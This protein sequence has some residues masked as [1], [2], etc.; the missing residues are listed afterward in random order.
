MYE[1]SS[2]TIVVEQEGAVLRIRLNR[3][4]RFNAWTY[5]LVTAATKL[6][7]Q[8]EDDW[9]IRA[10]V[11]EG[12][13]PAFCDGDDWLDMGEWPQEYAH[14]RPGGSHGPAPI[15]QQELLRVV[16]RLPKPTIAVMHGYA[17]GVG[18]DLACACDI[19]VCTDDT[20]LGDPRIHQARHVATG[21]TYTLPRLIGQS[22]AMRFLLL[23]E[24][25][26][27]KEAEHIGLVY[28][29]FPKDEFSRGVEQ[30]LAQLATMATRS[31][32]IIKQQL[33]DELDM[34]YETALMHS[35]AIRQTNVIEDRLEGGRAFLEKRDARFGGR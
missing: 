19:R 9:E 7:R 11:F 34:S 21:I 13:G 27:G 30:L 23:G 12:A 22:Q 8:A 28:K 17:L 33:L 35:M 20:I 4:D 1:S 32:A 29:S 24:Q 15:L 2:T 3:P 14:R 16:R 26:N 5:E 18:L 6:T 25:L 10:V 31:Y